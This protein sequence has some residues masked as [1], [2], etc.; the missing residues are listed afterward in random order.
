MV[1]YSNVTRLS[2]PRK[3]RGRGLIGI[4]GCVNRRRKA[5]HGYL[6]I[7]TEWLL[8]M[9]LKEKVIVEEHNLYDCQKTRKERN[10][11]DGEFARQTASDVGGED[12]WIWLKNAYRRLDTRCSRTS[13]ENKFDPA[14]HI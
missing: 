6:R 8:Q 13:F 14:Q 4:K 2:L 3:D 12:P 7:S 1:L 9:I 11:L 10:A 5:L